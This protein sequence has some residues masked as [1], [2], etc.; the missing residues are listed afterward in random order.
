MDDFR[1]DMYSWGECI[2][3]PGEPV[4]LRFL[5]LLMACRALKMYVSSCNYPNLA[6]CMHF[7]I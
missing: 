5:G 3:V 2:A 1:D 6:L 4:D 7:S